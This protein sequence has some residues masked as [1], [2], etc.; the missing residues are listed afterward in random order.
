MMVISKSLIVCDM[1]SGSE[2][3]TLLQNGSVRPV[4]LNTT[5][6]VQSSALTV[7]PGWVEVWLMLSDII[8]LLEEI[9][10][11]LKAIL[12]QMTK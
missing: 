9:L 6:C 8:Y 12:K 1:A 5:T 11:V 3:M 2:W 4:G 10:K 7:V